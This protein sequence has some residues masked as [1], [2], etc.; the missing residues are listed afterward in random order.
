MKVLIVTT[1]DSF[2]LSHILE[3][4]EYIR[5]KG[6]LVAVAAQKTSE[7][8]VKKIES[9]GFEFFDTKI[10][11]KSIGLLSQIVAIRNL[12]S[13]N[14]KYRPDICYHLGAK[15]IF[16]G[17]FASKLVNP[18]IKILNA[19]IGLGFVFSSHTL[20][21]MLLRP[22]VLMLYRLFLNPKSSRVIVENIDDINYFIRK[23]CLRPQDAFCILGAGVDTCII[24]PD[25]KILKNPICTVVLASRLIRDKGVIEFVQAAN[26]LYEEKIPVKMQIIGKPDY[27]NPSS[28]TRKE[29]SDLLCNP[30]V[31][32]LGFKDS[33]IPYLQRAQICCLPSYREGL[34]RVLVEACSAGL[35]II[36]TDAVGCREIIRDKNG[37]LV[38][39]KDSYSLYKS[40]KYMAEHPAEVVKMGERSR[41]VALRYFDSRIIC[42]RTYDVMKTLI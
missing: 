21:A 8:A 26:L 19:P 13:I 40:I 31:E 37:F 38:K 35:A 4:A 22:V 6:G 12:Y 11:R 34:P 33:V 9:Y 2:F 32:C 30:A 24:R 41:G 14:K 17:T 25:S 1:Q 10:E 5:S 23:G 7:V 36:T 20:K 16:Y 3:R 29:Y 39:T 42:R 18:E 15:S 28:I 27:G